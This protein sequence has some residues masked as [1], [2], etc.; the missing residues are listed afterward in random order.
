MKDVRDVLRLA[1]IKHGEANQMLDCE[2]EECVNKMHVSC[3][4]EFFPNLSDG[5]KARKTF[6][7]VHIP[8]GVGYTY[9]APK[10]HSMEVNDEV[11]GF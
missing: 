8:E 5:A 3:I 11:R 4:D 10:K 9:E 7:P 6:C 2:D 1:Q